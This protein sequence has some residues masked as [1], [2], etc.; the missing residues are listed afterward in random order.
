MGTMLLDELHLLHTHRSPFSCLSSC[1]GNTSVHVV[2]ATAQG[3]VLLKHRSSSAVCL[4]EKNNLSNHCSY[5]LQKKQNS[6]AYLESTV[7]SQC[8]VLNCWWYH[9]EEGG[10]S[11]WMVRVNFAVSWTF[12]AWQPNPLT[13]MTRAMQSHWYGKTIKKNTHMKFSWLRTRW[14]FLTDTRKKVQKFF[15]SVQSFRENRRS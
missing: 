7:C 1:H 10:I 8:Y 4:G 15:E 3:Q 14:K 11:E 2:V 5:T 12:D 6:L 13:G 9:S